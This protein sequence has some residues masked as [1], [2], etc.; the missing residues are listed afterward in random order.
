MLLTQEIRKEIIKHAMK[1]MKEREAALLKREYVLAK[2]CYAAS[3]DP[4]LIRAAKALIKLNDWW[5]NT[6]SIIRFNVAGQTIDLRFAEPV[7]I[8]VRYS[9]WGGVV[10]KAITYETNQKLVDEVRSLVS[11]KQQYNVDYEKALATLEA[12]LKSVRTTE[13][14]FKIW[15]E[16]KKHYSV[17][18]LVPRVKSG[19]PVAQMQS[20]NEMLGLV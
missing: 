17:P 7:P 18:P 1:P 11:D 20:L 16:G 8:T 14:L 3:F 2:K 13:S 5:V 10:G 12:V 6:T 15:P 4:K 19:V 9:N